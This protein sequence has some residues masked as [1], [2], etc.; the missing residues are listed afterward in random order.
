MTANNSFSQST[1]DYQITWSDGSQSII[2]NTSAEHDNCVAIDLVSVDHAAVLAM[3]A[4]DTELMDLVSE[5]IQ[6]TK[7]VKFC[8]KNEDN[9]WCKVTV[10]ASCSD[11]ND[12]CET[13]QGQIDYFFRTR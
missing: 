13:E 12:E 11:C 7:V 5:G 1:G 3:I 8:C 10:P 4:A 6:P 9:V 2:L